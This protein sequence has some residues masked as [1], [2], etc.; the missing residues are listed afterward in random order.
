MLIVESYM[1]D[2]NYV[3]ILTGKVNSDPLVRIILL[4]FRQ[5]KNLPLMFF[6]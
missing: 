5:T 1:F 2:E 3:V 4:V 6:H